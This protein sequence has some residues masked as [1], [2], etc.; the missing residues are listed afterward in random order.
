MREG[1]LDLVK[2]QDISL[3]VYAFGMLEFGSEP[4]WSVLT[5]QVTNRFEDLT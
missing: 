2:N 5:R 1:Q 4:L 3:M